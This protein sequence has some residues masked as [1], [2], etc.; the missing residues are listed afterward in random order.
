[1]YLFQRHELTQVCVWWCSSVSGPDQGLVP[2]AGVSSCLISWLQHCRWESSYRLRISIAVFSGEFSLPLMIIYIYLFF[3]LIKKIASVCYIFCR[4]PKANWLV[5][6]TND[7]YKKA[8]SYITRCMALI[9]S[10]GQDRAWACD[11]LLDKSSAPMLYNQLSLE[12]AKVCTTL[13]WTLWAV[14]CVWMAY[15]FWRR[16]YFFK[17][18]VKVTKFFTNEKAMLY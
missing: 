10:S 18:G 6:R 17:L 1:M 12:L 9:T 3:L 11:L 7:L 5:W 14:T 8:N 2:W 16:H 13:I 15:T 4:S